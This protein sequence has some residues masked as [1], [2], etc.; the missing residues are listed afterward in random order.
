[1]RWR[2]VVA[3]DRDAKVSLAIGK[4]ASQRG[5]TID[6]LAFPTYGIPDFTPLP[7]SAPLP[8]VYAIARQESAFDPNALSGAG[9][10]GLMQM[11]ASTARRTA[12]RAGLVFNELRMRADPTFN[13]Q[14][15]AAHLG[16]LLG[17]HGNSTIL[18][19]AAYN[20][21]GKRVKEWIDAYGDPRRAGVDVVDWIE[22]IPFTETRNYVQRVSEN[23]AVYRARLATPHTTG[24]HPPLR[25]LSRRSRWRVG[26]S[27]AARDQP[28]RRRP[29]ARRLTPGVTAS[30]APASASSA[31]PLR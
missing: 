3:R 10:M 15:G 6:D 17:E 31:H 27:V 20:A 18:T 28:A 14:L 11:I 7:N 9:A 22:R 16:E 13:A 12:Q 24:P 8:L 19:L 2:R 21:G 23:L 29:V 4:L 30:P 26:E 5:V 1:M 25:R